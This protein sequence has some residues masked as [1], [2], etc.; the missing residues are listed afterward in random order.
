MDLRDIR[1]QILALQWSNPEVIICDLDDTLAASSSIL[2]ARFFILHVLLR[3]TYQ[4]AINRAALGFELHRNIFATLE[5]INCRKIIILSR[6]HDAIV[7]AIIPRAQALLSTHGYQ[8]LGGVGTPRN[9][10]RLTTEDKLTLL[11]Q[12][13]YLVADRFEET[14]LKVYPRFISVDPPSWWLMRVTLKAQ[15]ILY[16]FKFF[17]HTL[18]SRSKTH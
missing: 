12:D 18:C 9:H 7:Q 4:L 10:Q 15:K 8:V 17:S 14:K 16:A 5:N 1:N 6:N 3:Y 11:P 2:Y 13:A